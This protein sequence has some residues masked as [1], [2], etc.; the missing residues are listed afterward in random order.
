MSNTEKAITWVGLQQWWPIMMAII[1]VTLY[2]ANGFAAI[3]KR[4][5]LIEQKLDTLISMQKQI[6][7]IEGRLGQHEIRLTKLER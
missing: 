5:S 6:D 1:G 4:Q 2:M 7:N 3:D